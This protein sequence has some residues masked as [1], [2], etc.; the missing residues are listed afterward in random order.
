M[1]DNEIWLTAEEVASLLGISVRAVRKNADAGKYGEV[2]FDEQKRRGGK[3]GQVRLIPLS[4]LPEQAK[5]IY[6]R[7]HNM[8]MPTDDGW[9]REPQW[10][11]ERAEERIRILTA[12]E[13]YISANNSRKVNEVTE[14]FIRQWSLL[15]DTEPFSMATLYR[16][17]KD[18]RAG[19]RTALL[20][21]WGDGK[22][23]RREVDKDAL[24]FFVSIYGTVQ[25][26]SLAD[27]YRD[28]ALVAVE[29]GWRIPSLRTMGRIIQNDFPE[30]FWI[31]LREGED[32]Y[33][34]TQLPFIHRDPDSIR[35]GEVWV[36]DCHTLDLFC[37][38]PTGQPVRPILSGWL[39][40][41]SRTM[42]G[43]FIGYSGN[44]DSVMAAFAHAGM[45]P[46]VGLP[47]FIYVD[48]GREYDNKQFAY[49]GHRRK[50]KDKQKYDEARILSLVNQLQID[51]TFAIPRNARAKVIE[52][53]FGEVA[54][55]F[56]K[57]FPTYCGSDN[58]E[59]PEGLEQVLKNQDNLPD[60][61]EVRELFTQWVMSDYNQTPSQGVG[62]KGESPV[63]TFNRTRG[64]IRLAPESVLRLCCMR[65]S[66]PIT[67]KNAGISVN[68]RWY[69]N[70]D[71]ITM[72]D[73][74]VYIRYRIE[75]PS[76][77][78]VF[79]LKDE[80]ICDA[81]LDIPLPSLNA[82]SESLRAKKRTA[83]AADSRIRAMEK[84]FQYDGPQYTVQD[85]LNLKQQ[86]A[87]QIE[88]PNV[89]EPVRISPE[90]LRSAIEI[91]KRIAVGAED[92]VVRER[93]DTSID[94]GF[95]LLAKARQKMNGGN[96]NG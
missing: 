40:F 90:L 58:K 4:G 34:K 77:V 11:R 1:K 73:Q 38:G 53:A 20:P 50:T 47:W 76:K 54:R 7:E 52:R 68:G 49:G 78:F 44:T 92:R 6:T 32:A 67:V 84:D 74:R 61:S 33:Q 19:G 14:E 96:N 75:E 3:N 51:A 69:Q 30:A 65:H 82:D 41:R 12:W 93:V 48:N 60:L 8:V 27:C 28:L 46:S 22:Q 94:E 17:R 15:H 85:I 55:R 43:W 64:T 42:V 25:K 72:N 2:R 16:W 36:G 87:K 31:K 18:F 89:I 71:L 83:K 10:K 91:D 13:R 59:R 39:D 21:N 95:K 29:N 88:K 26:R 45:S 86:R 5:I 9:D 23:Q 63:Q 56:S 62:R 37:K 79:S 70:P 35:A 57:L 24:K 80:Y 66:Q 81:A